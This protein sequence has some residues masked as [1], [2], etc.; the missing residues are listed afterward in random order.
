M[1]STLPK[2]V[3]I[4][5]DGNGRWATKQ[6]LPRVAGHRAGADSVRSIIEACRELEIPALTLF[7]FSSEN[8]SRPLSEVRYLMDLLLNMLKREVTKLAE[9][10]VQLKVIGDRSR[11]NDKL[12]TA[13]EDA[14]ATTAA[15]QGL[16]L[17]LAINYGGRWDITQAT[18]AIAEK[19]ANG[20]LEAQDIS[21][22]LMQQHM[23]LADLPE[24]DL[25]IRTSGEYRISNF[26][27][28]Q[29]AY[30]EL[31]FATEYWPDFSREHFLDALADFGRRERR[32][33]LT[34]EQLCSA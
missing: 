29:M 10:G 14:E 9:N 1:F 32:F 11:L 13:I 33:G 8:W 15:N 4:I 25:F 16:A 28:W 3:A 19:V 20:S 34:D 12:V 24:P 18:K 22:E 27:L 21:E 23:S 31:H 6:G 26:L 5:M 17:R 7:A 30:S 2:H